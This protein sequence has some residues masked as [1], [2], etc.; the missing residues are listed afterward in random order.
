MIAPAFWQLIP[1]RALLG[2]V[3]D[4]DPRCL[5]VSPGLGL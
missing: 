5:R 2:A 4:P 3:A 1:M